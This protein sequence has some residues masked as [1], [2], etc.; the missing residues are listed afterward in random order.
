V[1][2]A[3]TR[4]NLRA[5]LRASGSIPL[6]MDGVRVPGAPGLHWDGGVL[7][8]HLDLD[9]AGARTVAERPTARRA[10]QARGR[11]TRWAR[12]STPPATPTR[13]ASCSIRTSTRTSSRAG[14][15]RGCGG[16]ARAAAATPRAS[17]APCS[18]H[19]RRRSSRRFPGGK[20]PDR[21]DFYALDD[22]AA[23]A[24]GAPWSTRARAWATS[25]RSCWRPGASPTRC[26]LVAE[27][28][29]TGRVP[30]GVAGRA[31]AV[32]LPST[33]P[34][35]PSRVSARDRYLAFRAAQ[36]RPPALAR[37]TVRARG[38]DFAVWTSPAVPGAVPPLLRERR[39]AV[40]PQG[41]VADA[42]AARGGPAA[43]LYDQRGRGESAAPPGTRAARIEHDAGDLA[44]LRAAAAPLLGRDADA[45][46]DVLGH[47]WGGG[48]A[49]LAA[50]EDPAGVRRLV[51]ADP[52]GVTGDWLPA[53]H[54]RALALLAARGDAA[55]H[56]ALAASDPAALRE[57]EPLAHAAYARAFYPAWFAD[58]G[59]A[60]LFV[61]PARRAR[62]AAR[63]PPGSG[64]TATTGGTRCVPCAR[65]R[66]SSTA[67]RTR[68]T[69]P[70]PARPSRGSA[71]SPVR[72]GPAR[73]RGTH[74]VLGGAGA[75]FAAVESFLDAPI[76]APDPPATD[77]RP[78]S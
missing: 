65:P 3:L 57:P 59:L 46:W 74:A 63:S 1:H 38:L 35:P 32:T 20:I 25:S 31:P 13:A 40:R 61:P 51:L 17:A 6:L 54:G 76:L 72:P 78:Q 42:R 45:P 27:T 26:V 67:R 12:R 23:A 36:G 10:R 14:S 71:G 66:S 24:A 2:R 44:A 55:A 29:A 22:A 18:S 70:C 77:G 64:A 34:P 47:S 39:P 62:R 28:V 11:A 53:L 75:F 41:A 48:I 19:R 30:E 7:D 68:S 43:R 4:E 5:A 15:T 21:Q 8:Y 58:G 52:V 37:H 9:F 49:M 69:R 60:R 33:R 73:R 16:A 56:D 50:A